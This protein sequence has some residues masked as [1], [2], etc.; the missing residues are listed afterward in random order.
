MIVFR[1]TNDEEYSRGRSP[2]VRIKVSIVNLKWT[3]SLRNPG[4]VLFRTPLSE[5]LD[6]K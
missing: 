2:S 5:H 3:V 1:R 4:L 6:D